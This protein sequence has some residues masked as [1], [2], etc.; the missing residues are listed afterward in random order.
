MKYRKLGKTGVVVSEL[1]LGTMYFGDE[2][3]ESEAFSILDRFTEAG[4][5]L[6]DTSNV[7][8][9]G[10]SEEIIGRWLAA[11]P[12]DITNRLILTTKGRFNPSPDVNDSG[13]SRRNLQRSLDASLKRLGIEQVDLYQL[14]ASDMKTPVEETLQF[15]DD[16]V[17]SGKINYIGLSNFTGWQLQL[18]VSTAKTMGVHIPVTLQPQYSLLSRE[19]EWEIVPAALHNNIGL[20]PWSP[21]AGGFLSGKYQRG[22]N[23]EAATRAGSEK[24]LYQYV[25][26]EYAGS[27]RNWS[28]IDRVTYIAR[29]IGATPA[30]VALRWIADRQGVIAPICGARSLEHLND[31]LGMTNVVLNDEASKVLETVSRPGPGGYPYGEFG[32]WQRDRWMQDG[33]PAPEPVV[34]KGSEHPL[35]CKK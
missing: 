21:L 28:T 26:A 23:P 8:V 16:A 31:N 15:L 14:H 34:D 33:S 12:K 32:Q 5:T 3:S 13:L 22:S 27:E 2:T 30:Q 1:A 4:G 11:R 20:L 10:E 17:R 6:I 25:S 35:G 7:Y 19:I 24:P 29:E 9:G 18:M